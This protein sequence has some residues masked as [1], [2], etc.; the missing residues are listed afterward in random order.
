MAERLC[1][2]LVDVEMWRSIGINTFLTSRNIDVVVAGCD[3]QFV[4]LPS[5]RPD[6]VLL[7]HAFIDFYG[8]AVID[9]MRFMYRPAPILVHGNDESAETTAALIRR[10]VR[11]YFLLSAPCEQLLGAIEVV[12]SGGV[13]APRRALALLA[14]PVAQQL[15]AGDENEQVLLHLLRDGLSNK[16]IAARLGVAEVTVKSRLTRLYRRYGVKTRLQL[17]T[18]AMRQKTL[19]A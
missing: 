18:S 13:W 12:M 1:A 10:G 19:S 16:E 2:L 14:D 3:R 11:G 6:V 17:L 9:R 4:T 8:D 7:A 15:V 5:I